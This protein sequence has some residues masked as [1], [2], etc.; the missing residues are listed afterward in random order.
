MHARVQAAHLID[1]AREHN[2]CNSCKRDFATPQEG[3]DFV[4]TW[5]RGP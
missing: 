3:A 5:V 2:G 4:A 1:H